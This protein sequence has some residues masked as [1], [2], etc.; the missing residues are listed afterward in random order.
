ML[1]YTLVFAASFGFIFLKAFQQR[2]V[3]FDNYGWVVPT[4]LAMAGAEVFVIANI[5][6]NGWVWPLVL[7]IGLGSGA[8]A[9]VAMWA[10][11]RWVK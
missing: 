3:A 6:R 7:V 9:L 8:G 11:R 4:S 1:S 5:A 2:N 10:H